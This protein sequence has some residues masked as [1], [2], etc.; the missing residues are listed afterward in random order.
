MVMSLSVRL[1]VNP[2]PARGGQL[3]LS[4]HYVNGAPV[5]SVVCMF[6]TAKSLKRSWGNPPGR[7]GSRAQLD[8]G[9]GGGY[10]D[11]SGGSRIR[12][13]NEDVI[14]TGL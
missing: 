7:A 8:H 4:Q 5:E 14:W 3:L 6:A 9:S 12:L 2:C 1:L 13:I 11:G 10:F